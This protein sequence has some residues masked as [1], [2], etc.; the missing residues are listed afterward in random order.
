MTIQ[1]IMPLDR[2]TFGTLLTLVIATMGGWLGHWLA[3][4]A[5]W[6]LGALLATLAGAFKGFPLRYAS[7]L[8]SGVIVLAGISVGSMLQPGMLHGMTHWAPS[9]AGLFISLLLTI[10]GVTYFLNHYGGCEQNT[11]VLAAYPGHMMMIMQLAI[12]HTCDVH[13]VTTIQSLRML[14]LVLL[15]PALAFIW[16]PEQST[17]NESTDYIAFG[18]LSLAG[19]AGVVLARLLNIPASLL[20][21]AMGGSGLAALSGTS[22]GVLPDSLK[23][24]IFVLT[25]AMIGTRFVNTHWSAIFKILPVALT[26]MSITM[27]ISAAIAVPVAWITDVPAMQLLLAYSPGGA[28]VMSLIALATG[29]DPAFVGLHHIVRLLAMAAF[30][31]LLIKFAIR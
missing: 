2:T 16:M 30:F 5:G 15:L 27:V 31:P 26:S 1:R 9:L 3:A 21:G 7:C 19:L 18:W 17:M 8:Q 10:T 13:K 14:F 22:I 24:T 23:V 29:H 11:S 4:D 28:E 12:Q 6:L 20:V 25:G